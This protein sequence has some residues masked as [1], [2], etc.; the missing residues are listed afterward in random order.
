M[1]IVFGELGVEREVTQRSRGGHSE[2]M[3]GMAMMTGSEVG[4]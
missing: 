1:Y 3:F 4:V 2:V